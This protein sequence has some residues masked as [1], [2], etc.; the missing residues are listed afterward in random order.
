MWSNTI[1]HRIV[2]AFG[3]AIAV[4]TIASASSIDQI[5]VFGD[6]LSD[7]GNAG[8]IFENYPALIPPGAPAPVPPNYTQGS[9]TDGPDTIPATTGPTGLWIDQFAAKIG[10]DD[11]LPEIPNYLDPALPPGTNYAVASATSGSGLPNMEAQVG[12]YLAQHPIAD[13]DSLY[14]IFG[15]SNDLLD[16]PPGSNPATIAAAA[17]ADQL[18]EIEALAAS[19]ADQFLWFNVPALNLT[20]LAAAGGPT[21][22][23]FL[24]QA[25]QDFDTDW[26]ADLASLDSNSLDVAGVN[27]YTL[28]QDIVASPSAYGFTNV[29]TPAQG[30][31]GVNPNEYLFWDSEHPTTAG[32]ALIADA[33]YDALYPTPEPSQLTLAALGLL[34]VVLLRRRMI[35]IGH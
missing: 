27:I 3:L 9:Y 1:M 13:P 16:A 18:G 15:G 12:V 17:V 32:D 24:A 2:L 5:Y 4:S 7:N 31:L 6:S 20:P 33:A 35:S 22:Q 25:S 14:V 8:F 34:G 10:V 23:A 21:V 26:A 11:P 29:T 28:M 19:G 30:L